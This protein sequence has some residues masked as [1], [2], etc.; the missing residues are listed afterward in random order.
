[1]KR[2]PRSRS[3]LA[4]LWAGLRRSLLALAKV[5]FV[6]LL[7]II[8]VPLAQL[9]VRPGKMRRGTESGQVIKRD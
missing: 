6:V 5:L 9:L 1:M 3:L 4:R 8:P 7:V 2:T